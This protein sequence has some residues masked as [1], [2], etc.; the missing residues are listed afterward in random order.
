MNA[1]V[2][3]VCNRAVEVLETGS[4]KPI[5]YLHGFMDVHGLKPGWMAFHEALAGAGRLIAPAH[6]GVGRTD[7]NA[8]IVAIEDVVF[9]YL[10][11]LDALELAQFDLVGHG[12]GG[13]I[14]AEL[15]ARHPEKVARLALIDAM[16]LFVPGQ[17][18]GD[19]F[20]MAQPSDGGSNVSLRELLF[21]DPNDSLA[22][23]M[24]PDGRGDLDEE[25]RRY[26]MLR[27]GSWVGFKPPYFYNRALSNR[28]HRIAAP[29]LVIWGEDDRLVPPAHGQRYAELLPGAR[30]LN[31]VRNAGHSVIAEKPAAVAELVLEFLSS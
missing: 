13:W 19:I 18:T 29:A 4:G 15:A 6:P 10:E 17:P 8:D 25:L 9:H 7:E 5:V 1:R 26:Q 16:G 12:V 21:R 27:F 30:G 2:I 24:V 14:A 3:E 20:M 22:T 31:V 23:E 11:A 28:L